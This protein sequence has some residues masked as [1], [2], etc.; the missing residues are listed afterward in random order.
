M[1]WLSGMLKGRL[2][3]CF[4]FYAVNGG[5]VFVSAR[6]KIINVDLMMLYTVGTM[7]AA[8]VARREKDTNH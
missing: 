2:P 5:A 4:T 7:G 6:G 1:G 3:V 8:Y